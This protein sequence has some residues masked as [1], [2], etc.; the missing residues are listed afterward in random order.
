MLRYNDSRT[1]AWVT[2]LDPADPSKLVDSGEIDF[3]Y[4]TQF[5]KFYLLLAATLD[6]DDRVTLAGDVAA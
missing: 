6:E 1:K 3:P 2:K 4:G 5:S